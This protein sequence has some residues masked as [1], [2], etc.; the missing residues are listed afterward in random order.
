MP[1]RKPKNRGGRPSKWK[2][3]AIAPLA[4]AL[5]HRASITG[6]AKRAGVGKSKLSRWIRL[7]EQRDPRFAI[8]LPLVKEARRPWLSW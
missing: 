8:L 4:I 1:R 5:D 3:V 2:P 7:A 6:A